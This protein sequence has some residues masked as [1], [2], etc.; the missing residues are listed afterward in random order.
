MQ[1]GLFIK[2]GIQ[3]QGTE[4][5]KTIEFEDIDFELGDWGNCCTLVLRVEK[6]NHAETVWLFLA[7]FSDK[8]E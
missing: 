2:S 4:K 1:K 7:F 3:E 5:Y 8:K 6:K